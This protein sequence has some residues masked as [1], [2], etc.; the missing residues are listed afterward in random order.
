MPNIIKYPLDPTGVS[1]TNL[2]QGEQHILVNRPIRCIATNYGSYYANSMVITDLSNNKILNINQWYPGELYDVPTA[3]Y[4]QPIY[5]LVVITDATVGNTIS[6]QYQAVG[7]EFSTSETALVN[8][9]ETLNL[10]NRPVSWPNIIL[11]PTEYP[12]SEHLHDAGDVYGFEYVVHALERVKSAIEFGSGI[13]QDKLY[14]YVD[15]E[16][17]R[18]TAVENSLINTSTDSISDEIARAEAAESILSANLA[19]LLSTVGTLSTVAHTGDYNNLINIPVAVHVPS[20]ISAF[21]NDVGYQTAS[22]V[23][24]S[25]NTAVGTLSTVAHTG[26]Y[27]NLINIPVAVHV[28]SNISAFINDVGY[29]A[30]N[31]RAVLGN[32]SAANPSLAFASDG[33]IDTGFFWKQDGYTHITNNGLESGYFGPGGILNMYG[34][35]TAVSFNGVLYGNAATATNVDWSGVVNRPSG[36][37]AFTNDV[38][39]QTASQ[40]TSS[41]NTAVGTLSTVAH[42]GDYNNLINIPVAVGVPTNVSA[43]TNDVGYQTASQVTSSINNQINTSIPTNISAFT[44]DSGYLTA[45]ALGNGVTSLTLGIKN[46]T[47]SYITVLSD[48]TYGTNIGNLITC[49]AA[50][51]IAIIIPLNSSVNYPIGASL[52]VVALGAGKVTFVGGGGVTIN[53]PGGLLSIGA[54]YAAVSLI[55]VSTNV[56]ILIGQL[57][58]DSN[59]LV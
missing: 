32:G 51:A 44:N 56:W 57:S 34:A 58:S 45:S 7:G 47:T 27:N 26:D 15:I 14:A 22:Q 4:G 12:P 59:W 9:L 53:S 28:P 40:V 1:V 31:G 46:I 55:Q 30:T 24:S 3:L 41:I 5:A 54:Q 36:V 19:T 21:T 38:G 10:D 35:V 23:T 29:I 2:V 49:S 42:T 39:Y 6:I 16:T 37:S 48:A 8:L 52:Q 25:V 43:F 11:K 17:N 13:Y 33:A 50:T 18:A 20:N